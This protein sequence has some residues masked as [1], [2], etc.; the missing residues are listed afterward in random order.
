MN[1]Y[2]YYCLTV[3]VLFLWGALSDERTCLSFVTATGLVPV[4]D[5]V[6]SI[7]S[8]KSFQGRNKFAVYQTLHRFLLLQCNLRSQ[9]RTKV[10][11]HFH[12]EFSCYSAVL[13]WAVGRGPYA[14][15]KNGSQH[16]EKNRSVSKCCLC[17]VAALLSAN[18]T[19]P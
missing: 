15:K 12:C 16:S 1:R 9:L 19:A 13:F 14:E 6:Y 8:W 17:S 18:S 4:A 10:L 7:S 5:G 2:I 11:F 3:T